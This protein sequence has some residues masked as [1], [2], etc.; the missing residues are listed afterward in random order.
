KYESETWVN[1]Q[2]QEA[3]RESEVP[4]V[5]E[6]AAGRFWCGAETYA[7]DNGKAD[8]KGEV[9]FESTHS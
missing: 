3:R 7:G 4:R 9:A 5:R 6:R 1:A 2:S 8:P